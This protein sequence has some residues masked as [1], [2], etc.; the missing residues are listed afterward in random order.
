MVGWLLGVG[1]LADGNSCQDC[2]QP[3]GRSDH[4]WVPFRRDWNPSREGLGP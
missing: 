4:D 3:H 1:L 2:K